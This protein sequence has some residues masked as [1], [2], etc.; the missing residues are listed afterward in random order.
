MSLIILALAP[1]FIIAF[2]IYFRDKYEREPVY[3][4]LLSLI[5]GAFIT[6]PIVFVEGILMGFSENL[7]GLMKP[8]WHAFAVAGFT[9]ELF[10]YLA[11]YLLIWKSREF[12]EKFDGIVYSVFISLGFA[13][14]ENVMYVLQSGGTTGLIRAFTAVPAHTIFGITM[15]FFFGYARFSLRNKTV[16]KVKALVYPI[17]LHGIY[18]FI[19]MSGIAWLS[20][21]FVA[22]VVYLYIVGFKKL[23]S[24]SDQSVFRTDF[25]LLEQKL[26]DWTHDNESTT[27]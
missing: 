27:V 25:K 20:I 9:E 6:L 24:F 13:G 22:F 5:A 1:V 10:K 17:L 18:D 4:L 12:N 23:K 19:L 3:L 15:G 8:A 21:V 16:W 2:Y 11:L 7:A 26:N 14:V